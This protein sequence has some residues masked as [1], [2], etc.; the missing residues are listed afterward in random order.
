MLLFLI[1][2][3]D[4][5]VS[6]STFVEHYKVQILSINW[7]LNILLPVLLLRGVGGPGSGR[8]TQVE[9]LL[10][11]VDGWVH[12]SMGDLIRQELSNRSAAEEKWKMAAELVSEGEFISDVGYRIYVIELS[13][14]NLEK[15]T[16]DYHS[17]NVIL[18]HYTDHRHRMN[19]LLTYILGAYIAR[20]LCHIVHT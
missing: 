7:C 15:N 2:C 19:D 8:C 11:R 12:I 1:I 4:L 14:K 3:K 18:H 10:T 20:H 6:F 13:W 17:D 9:T 5:F 16:L